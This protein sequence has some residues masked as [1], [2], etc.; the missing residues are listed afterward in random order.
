MRTFLLLVLFVISFTQSLADVDCVYFS[1]NV[2]NSLSYVPREQYT[3][4]GYPGFRCSVKSNPSQLCNSQCLSRNSRSCSGDANYCQQY[5]CLTNARCTCLST[6]VTAVYPTDLGVCI[7]N[8]TLP[9]LRNS[10]ITNLTRISFRNR[11]KFDI[12][13]K[14][15]QISNPFSCQRMAVKTNDMTSELITNGY[16]CIIPGIIQGYTVYITINS[17]SQIEKTTSNSVFVWDMPQD[18]RYESGILTFVFEHGDTRGQFSIYHSGDNFVPS[19]SPLDSK[20]YK[21][22]GNMTIQM[23]ILFVISMLMFF[24]TTI[25]IL[26]A[27]T[28]YIYCSCKRFRETIKGTQKAYKAKGMS[29]VL[30]QGC[31]S[32]TV[33]QIMFVT[34]ILSVLIYAVAGQTCQ[35]TALVGGTLLTCS[36][37]DSHCSYTFNGRTTLPSVGTSACISLLASDNTTHG[38]MVITYNKLTTLAMYEYIYDHY[39]VENFAQS[40]LSC[41]GQSDSV[42]AIC[43][44]EF[45]NPQLD[46][47]HIFTRLFGSVYSDWPGQTVYSA[48]CTSCEGCNSP[49]PAC[50]AGRYVFRPR[51]QSYPVYKFI[52]LSRQADIT[53]EI[54]D[55]VAT[56]RTVYKGLSISSPVDT[57]DI[58][59]AMNGFFDN[60]INFLPPQHLLT[61]PFIRATDG[62]NPTPY[63]DICYPIENASPPG[64]P[65]RGTVGEF[66][67]S[68]WDL[69]KTGKDLFIFPRDYVTVSGQ[70][71]G[72]LAFSFAKPTTLGVH[73][74]NFANY[75]DSSYA[76]INSVPYNGAVYQLEDFQ[77]GGEGSAITLA[78]VNDFSRPAEI[79]ISVSD[80]KVAQ[81]VSKVCPVITAEDG[82]D[83]ITFRG[84]YNCV[85]GASALV[86][87]RSAGDGCQPGMVGL[88]L[89]YGD[90]SLVDSEVLTTQSLRLT[91]TE[92]LFMLTILS[93]DSVIPTCFIKVTG[94]Y[95]TP[96]TIKVNSFALTE[97]TIVVNNTNDS[98][99]IN[100]GITIGA[101]DKSSSSSFFDDVGDFFSGIGS[102]IDD[103]IHSLGK[104]LGL[105][106]LFNSDFIGGL[107]TLLM[108]VVVCI[109][110]FRV[111]T[112]S[113]MNY[114]AVKRKDI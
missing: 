108:I 84:C 86:K 21:Y 95:S 58:K 17:R 96:V 11:H 48:G 27:L 6:N 80:F 18:W 89:V 4:T 36:Q 114:T 99:I 12:R 10:S 90:G 57:G 109:V 22:F 98:D 55:D 106:S 52:G 54:S 24:L 76:Q 70:G 35:S 111:V 94:S 19:G 92:Q 112:W 79:T 67:G 25:A 87:L 103:F 9:S 73:L 38:S 26:T 37:T 75:T 33:V 93:R 71:T 44:G 97:P 78:Q 101:S 7:K 69:K 23:R 104:H 66:Q 30:K 83:S 77:I 28:E 29:I 14:L 56:S 61:S 72:R 20:T 53:I 88:A 60:G 16:T 107:I 5:T 81:V 43:D 1:K 34:A 68:R 42:A 32:V 105:G 46:P 15:L 47:D 102:S 49:D 63:I 41:A 45:A 3:P 74:T 65:L 82:S 40:I 64:A 2:N 62:P 113:V 85:G 100:S 31:S 59:I 8:Y 51:G 50:L 110:G 91:N 13:R 39:F